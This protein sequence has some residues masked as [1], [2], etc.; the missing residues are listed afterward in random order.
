MIVG[1]GIDMTEV[2]R[3]EAVYRKFGRRFLEKI[4]T[5][6]E[7]AALPA[8]PQAYLAGRFSAKEAAV[9]ALGTGFSSGIGPRHIEVGRD[10]QGAPQLRL[11]ARAQSRA[12]QLGV[13]RC[14]L[15]IS[16][17]RCAAVAVVILEG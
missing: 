9:K 7:L 17:E 10:A 13:K 11:L 12:R 1:L 4:L 2:A 8:R 16:H 3:L 5:P 15:S 6:A 14:H